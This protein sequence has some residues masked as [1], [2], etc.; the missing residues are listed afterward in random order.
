MSSLL[1]FQS[2]LLKCETAIFLG[3]LIE[4]DVRRQTQTGKNFRPQIVI[5][6]MQE[7]AGIIAGRSK[8]RIDPSTNTVMEERKR[9]QLAF[10]LVRHLVVG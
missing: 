9:I 8:I 3:K 10:Q 6:R 7:I 5:L 2:D 1:H 4:G